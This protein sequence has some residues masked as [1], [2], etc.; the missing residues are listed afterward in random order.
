MSDAQLKALLGEFEKIGVSLSE[1][2]RQGL[3]F[4][5]SA[6]MRQ[7][8][9]EGITYIFI[10]AALFFL[11]W[12][13]RTRLLP[14][15]RAKKEK[16]VKDKE[17]GEEDNANGLIMFSHIVFWISLLVAFGMLTESFTN[18]ANPQWVALNKILN[19]VK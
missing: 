18:L 3:Q 10:A 14:A 6:A 12:I 11:A 5:Y 9:V 2:A 7:V 19:L 16:A 4:A 15:V 17:W 1:T 8:V 13:T